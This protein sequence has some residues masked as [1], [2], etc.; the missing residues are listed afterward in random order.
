MDLII[1]ATLAA[2]MILLAAGFP[3]QK[4][5]KNYSAKTIFT[6]ATNTGFNTKT[7][8]ETIFSNHF[9]ADAHFY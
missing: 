3:C 8:Y 4:N 9:G 1:F 2:A 7:N 5:I 6:L